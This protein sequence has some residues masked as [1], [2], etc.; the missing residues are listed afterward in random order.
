M[1]TSFEL[2]ADYRNDEGKGASRRL[3]RRGKI[4][5]IIYGGKLAPRQ[6]IFDHQNLMTMI[7]NEKLYS[8]I[9]RIKVGSESQEAI[10]KDVQMHPAKNAIMHIDL[11][12]VLA[13]EKI[14]IHLPIH[15]HGAAG[16]PGVKT[17]GGVVSHRISDVEVVC[18]PKDLPDFLELD[19]SQMKLNETKFLSDLPLPPGV[20]IPQLQQGRN[21][22]VVSVHAPRA[23]E[24]EPT[25]EAAAA[26][27]AVAAGTTAA[28]PAAGEAAKA[29]AAAPAK[30]EGGG[31][32]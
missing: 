10:I 4:P 12:R 13:D 17:E 30:K 5:A 27:G 31:K 3:R 1:K 11:Q 2:V 28:A 6:V 24:P 7:D 26:E 8:S 32:K 19:L 20:V 14:R 16:S 29:D 22:A 25:A 15:C 21:V 18:L 9:I 23:A